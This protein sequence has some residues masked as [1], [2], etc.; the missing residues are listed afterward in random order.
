VLHSVLGAVTLQLAHAALRCVRITDTK[1]L[2]PVGECRATPG[3]I[4]FEC[5]SPCLADMVA[6]AT[7]ARMSLSRGIV[8]AG[9]EGTDKGS[10]LFSS[11]HSRSNMPDSVPPCL[12][13]VAA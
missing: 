1:V 7:L 12:F 2:T 6:P 13:V 4:F 9:V 5:A 10:L 3:W 8:L 11:C